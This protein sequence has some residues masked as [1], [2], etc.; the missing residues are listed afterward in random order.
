MRT[1]ALV[2]CAA[3]AALAAAA[4][5]ARSQDRVLES[6]DALRRGLR[7]LRARR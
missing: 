6:V 4:G 2:I 5:P 1:T 7:G 3:V